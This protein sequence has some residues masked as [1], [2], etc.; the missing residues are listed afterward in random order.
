MP[1]GPTSRPK[2]RTWITGSAADLAEW[3]YRDGP[4]RIARSALLLRGRR[5][6]MLSVL[7]EG[8][9][10]SSD[11][12]WTMRLSLPPA[13]AAAPL[14]GSRAL[15]LAESKRRGSAQVLP[16]GLPCLPYATDRGRSRSR[17]GS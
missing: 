1:G 17:A 13:I 6:A 3:T 9:D 2:P 11:V 10:A 5:L 14:A 7:I 16:I 12:G 15:V 8:R 4:T